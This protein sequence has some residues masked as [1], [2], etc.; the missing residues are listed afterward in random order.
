VFLC[1][2]TK[3]NHQVVK[4]FKGITSQ[5]IKGFKGITSQF[6]KG[7]KGINPLMSQSS[8]VLYPIKKTISLHFYVPGTS[9]FSRILLHEWQEIRSAPMC[10]WH[11]LVPTNKNALTATYSSFGS[12]EI[13]TSGSSEIST[14]GSSILVARNFLF[15][16]LG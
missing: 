6:I 5:F 14:S 2:G 9:E 10:V 1:I 13:S 8:P 7:F 15:V 11:V 12:S 4:G 3:F 16:N